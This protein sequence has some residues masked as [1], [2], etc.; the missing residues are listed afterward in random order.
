ML[1]PAGLFLCAHA[2][3]AANGIA[4][5]LI[6]DEYPGIVALGKEASAVLV[7]HGT[8]NVT[9]NAHLLLLGFGILVFIEARLDEFAK[10]EVAR[11]LVGN[12]GNV[13]S[14]QNVSFGRL[15]YLSFDKVQRRGNGEGLVGEDLLVHH[16]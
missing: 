8:D 16:D 4:R 7:L 9:V 3:V 14:K 5:G 10:N 1:L 12:F 6:V 13:D 15:G 2:K 11:L